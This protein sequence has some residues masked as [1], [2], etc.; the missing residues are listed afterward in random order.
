MSTAY[1]KQSPLTLT[2]FILQ[3]TKQ[4]HPEATGEFAI[5]MNAVESAAKFISSKVRAAGYVS[6]ISADVHASNLH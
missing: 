5:L 3:T 2:H 4:Y 6:L 1:S